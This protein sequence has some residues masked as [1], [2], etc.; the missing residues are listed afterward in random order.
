MAASH[1]EGM[2]DTL[3]HSTYQHGALAVWRLLATSDGTRGRSGGHKQYIVRVELRANGNF[4]VRKHWGKADGQA[5]SE[6]ASS[7]VGEYDNY[8]S[9]R[10]WAYDVVRGKL[11]GKYWCD[12]D[13]Q[14]Q[15][16]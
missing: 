6:L 13:K 12:Y 3:D 15:L 1:T 5:L 4:L 16:V 10:Y 9:A 14:I 11:N 7:V 2:S 8:A